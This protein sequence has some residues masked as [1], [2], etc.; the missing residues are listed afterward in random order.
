MWGSWRTELAPDYTLENEMLKVTLAPSSGSIV[1]L[2]DK[3]SGREWVPEGK[4][5]GAL[6]YCLEVSNQMS[7]WVIGEFASRAMLRDGTLKRIHTGAYINTWRWSGKINQTKLD[8]DITLRAGA[9]QVDFRLRVD[10]REMGDAERTPHLR[11][12]F[13]LAI[14]KPQARYEIPYGSIVRDTSPGEEVVGQRWADFSDA[15]G[16]GMVL[17]NTSKYGYRL[18]GDTLGLTLLRAS[19]HPDPLPDL[20]EHI[21]EY[22]LIPHDG[23]GSVGA[24]ME[25]GESVNVPLVALSCGFQDGALPPTQSLVALD[26]TNVRLVALKQSQTGDGII[27]RL[28]EV[29]GQETEAYITLSTALA[30]GLTSAVQV[31]TLEHPL[32]ENGAML[33]GQVVKVTVPAFGIVAVKLS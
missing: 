8:L 31:D 22:A 27:L 23:A 33:D 13:P 1:S 7:A 29:E 32:A 17:V 10:W 15:D 12:R 26:P 25:A 24:A 4:R 28:V 6:E 30:D 5:L 2:V 3:R 21:I 14:E 9:A 19:T 11:V 18:D 16:T 20:G